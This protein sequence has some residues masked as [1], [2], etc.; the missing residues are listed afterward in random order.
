MISRGGRWKPRV[1]KPGTLGKLAIYLGVFPLVLFAMLPQIG[2]VLISIG[3]LQPYTQG[4]NLVFSIPDN[5]LLYFEKLLIEDPD[6]VNYIKNTIVYAGVS[7]IIAVFLAIAVGYSVSRLKVR[8]I[9]SILDSLATA[10][11]AIPGL[12]MALGYYFLFITMSSLLPQGIGDVLSPVNP[13]FA[14]WLVFIIAFSVRRLPYVVR[15]V[16]AGFQQ[17]HEAL[18]ESA[19]NLGASR[20]RAVF[21]VIMPLIIGYVLSGALIG[22]IYM[23]TEVSTSVT[24]GSIRAD[25]APLTYYM[26]TTLYGSAG[27]GTF[28]VAVMGT[29][30]ILIQLIIVIVVVFVFKQRYAF[31]GV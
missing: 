31:I 28:R 2:V 7:I 14:A 21:G 12:V 11:L 13:G 5:P 1:Q 24:F 15:S 26:K 16:F 25:Q 8:Y 23:A 3:M 22:F 30:L 4:Y 27:Q 18:E 17:V 29:L 6:V 19:M 10:P 20:Y 9:P